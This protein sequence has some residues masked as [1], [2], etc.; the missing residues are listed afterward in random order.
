MNI[1]V[2]APRT[3]SVDPVTLNTI[4]GNCILPCTPVKTQLVS[5]T[6]NTPTL[7]M[8][9][10]SCD[11]TSEEAALIAADPDCYVLDLVKLSQGDVSAFVAWMV[12][13]GITKTQFDNEVATFAFLRSYGYLSDGV[14]LVSAALGA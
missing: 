5:I 8:A 13:K 2:I 10:F 4:V 12:S 1:L 3:V 6:D 14:A 7:N 9:V 11:V